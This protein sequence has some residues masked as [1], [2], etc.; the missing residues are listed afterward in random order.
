MVGE[1]ET[2]ELRGE[3]GLRLV[4][5]AYGPPDGPPALFFHGSGQTR[6]SWG[7]AAVELGRQGWR[8]YTVDHRG[9]GDSDRH[10]AGRYEHR[11]VAQDVIALCAALHRRPLVIGASLGGS[12]ALVAQG[13]VDEQLYRGLVLVDITPTV[14]VAGARRIIAFMSANPH[15]F[16]TLE[17]AATAIGAYRGEGRGAPSPQ[18]LTRVLRR[19]DAGRWH[20][21]WDPRLLDSRKPWLADPAAAQQAQDRL[22]TL[23]T[24]GARRIEAPVLLVRGGSSD[25]VTPEAARELCALIPHAGYVDVT[26]AGH[27]VAGDRNDAFTIAVTEFAAPLR[28][29]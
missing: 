14:D 20:W 12:A 5:D 29:G 23:M 18:G 8:A 22:R 3:D 25:V 24:A 11:D 17:A 15:G 13:E 21:H 9:H 27:M 10:H 2:V 16:A 7:R 1:R 4:A 28:D 26:D 6:Q 19:D